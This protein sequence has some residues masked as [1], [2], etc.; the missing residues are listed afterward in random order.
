MKKKRMLTSGAFARL[1][2]TTKET[3]R[4]YKE[5]GLLI[6]SYQGENGYFYYDVEQFYDFYAIS[7]FRMTG[8][9]LDE[10]R[11]CLLGESPEETLAQM[12]AQMQHLEQERRKLEQMEFL[13][14]STIQNWEMG[15]APDLLPRMAWFDKEHLL[16]IPAV[17]LEQQLCPGDDEDETIIALLERYTELCRQYD[18][19]SDY[20]LGA[21]HQRGEN[22]KPAEITHLYTRIKE[23]VS[24]PYY[25]EKPAGNYVYLCCRGRWD[26]SE[27][28]GALERYILEH[29]LNTVG[30]IY[31]YDLA[32]FMLNG[33]EKN[34]VSMVSVRLAGSEQGQ[35]GGGKKF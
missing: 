31:A 21:V 8:T 30:N 16:A 24:F 27:G 17:E 18:L 34:S 29:G 6:P 3:L 1:C 15:A 26:I 19:Q 25:L 23:K 2:G 32:G 5:I 9:P 7:M 11:R 13:L 28:Y 10:I 14:S 22:G 12:R 33:V 4:H 20:Q 35:R